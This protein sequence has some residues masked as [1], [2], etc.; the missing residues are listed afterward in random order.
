[1]ITILYFASLREALGLNRERLECA[2]LE[3]A[4]VASL[5]EH[6]R[7]R[8]TRFAEALAPTKNWRV[9]VNQEIATPQTNLADGDEVAFFPPVT[10]G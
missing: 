9:A 1:M 4:D 2:S 7:A 6:L 3:L 8:D 10:G 5:I